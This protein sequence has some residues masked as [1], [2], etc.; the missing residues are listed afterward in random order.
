MA[1]ILL[2][3]YRFIHS[4]IGHLPPALTFSAVTGYS[5]WFPQFLILDIKK[6]T[7]LSFSE[8]RN[9]TNIFIMLNLTWFLLHLFH[10]QLSIFNF[11][12][13]ASMARKIYLNQGIGVGGFRKIYGGRRR[14]GV[15]PPHFCK[16][17]GSIARHILQQLEKIGIVEIHANGWV[18][19][20]VFTLVGLFVLV[21]WMCCSVCSQI[22]WHVNMFCIS[23]DD[24]SLPT[25]KGILTRLLVGLQF[26][27]LEHY[28]IGFVIFT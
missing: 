3:I 21:P 10:G 19:S 9:T 17:S 8:G 2:A 20:F 15:A 1:C 6:C 4:N 16:S 12:V 25:V 18:L 7:W 26:L 28:V 5:I 23:V 11:W 13:T 27:H 24:A 22:F 14:N